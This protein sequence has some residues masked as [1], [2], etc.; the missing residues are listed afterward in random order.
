MA[1]TTPT[2]VTHRT[3]V[4]RNCSTCGGDNTWVTEGRRE[5]VC[6]S[7]GASTIVEFTPEDVIPYETHRGETF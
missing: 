4:P 3:D 2:I 7:C 1:T 5:A 6:D